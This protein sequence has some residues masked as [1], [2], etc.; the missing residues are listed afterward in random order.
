MKNIMKTLLVVLASF[1]T[2]T[3]VNA[4]ELTVS[5]SAKATYSI[6]SG[7]NGQTAVGGDKG[8][9]VANELNF[10]ASGELDNGWTWNYSTELDPAATAAGGAA[11]NDDSQLTVKTDFGTIGMFTSEG[12]LGT[13]LSFAQDAYALMSDTGYAEGK[14]EAANISGFNNMQY[15]LP[16]DILPFSTTFKAGYA[17][18]GNTVTG[19]S[20]TSN[21]AP[22]ASVGSTSQYQV[23]TVPMEGVK[24]LVSYLEQDSV[25]ASDEQSAEAGAV[26]ITYDYGNYAFGIGRSM[27]APR[28]ADDAVGDSIVSFTENTNFSVGYAVNDDLSVSYTRERSENE[29]L[30]STTAVYDVELDSFQ[31]AYTMGGMTVAVAHTQ[32]DNI[33]YIQNAKA[34]E[35]IIAVTM[36]F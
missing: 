7:F 32:M 11:L 12:G 25:L 29:T 33:G 20:N 6:V 2:I 27:N 9:A 24:V 18:S 4:G 34:D 26:S 30:T 21:V 22:S 8:V 13:H 36:A 23:T 19:S 31:A 10:T 1:A 35:T 28:I 5:G 17:T 15:H 14:T 16:A 3:S